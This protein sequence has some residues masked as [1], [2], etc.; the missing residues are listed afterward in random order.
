MTND[1]VMKQMLE[2]FEKF[3]DEGPND[4]TAVVLAIHWGD[5]RLSIARAGDSSTVR[6]LVLETA[7]KVADDNDEGDEAPKVH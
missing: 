7:L 4:D 6:G 5:G 3:K 2:L 1:E